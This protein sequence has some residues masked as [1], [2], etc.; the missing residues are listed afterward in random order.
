MDVPHSRGFSELKLQQ[1][2]FFEEVKAAGEYH[3][4]HVKRWPEPTPKHYYDVPFG[5][6][7]SGYIS[8]TAN[9]RDRYVG[10]EFLAK[11]KQTY[12]SLKANRA[13]IEDALGVT[14]D[15]QDLP[16]KARSKILAKKYGD[17][18]DEQER[19]ELRSWAVATTERFAD[20]FPRFLESEVPTVEPTESTGGRPEGRAREATA[21][22]L[23]RA[24]WPYPVNRAGE[25]EPGGFDREAL[26]AEVGN[27]IEEAHA[28]LGHT[29]GWRFLYS[30]A[31]TLSSAT[32]M[33]FF[34]FNPGGDW[35]QP[36]NLA[37]DEGNLY[38]VGHWTEDGRP[39]PLQDQVCGLFNAIAHKRGDITGDA[40]MDQC[41]TS[42]YVPFRSPSRDALVNRRDTLRF[43]NSLWT[44]VMA[45]LK[46]AAIICIDKEP[47]QALVKI[48]VGQGYHAVGA[49][50]TGPIGWG[51]VS[52]TEATFAGQEGRVV[53]IVRLP[54]LSR[55][56]IVGK[57]S[58]SNA[59]RPI[60]EQLAVSA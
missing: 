19:A 56:K 38:R 18:R 20:V 31:A 13:A 30:P 37:A 43:S 6:P 17:F 40:L 28:R 25:A 7:G 51:N 22:S 39:T 8:I 14:C 24:S 10:V 21:D 33:L 36:P 32:R 23:A 60:I 52:Y 27:E 59:L 42:N 2:A 49:E 50:R 47:Y 53:Y 54:H 12:S 3:A 9:W 11:N 15:W 45:Q 44:K 34:G 26:L 29:L 41:L 16:E 35:Y 48:L 46:P 5:Y 57:E 58:C 1:Q 4:P 55:Y